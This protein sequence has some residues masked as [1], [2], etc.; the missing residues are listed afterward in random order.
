ME[1][2]GEQKKDKITFF[3][4]FQPDYFWITRLN[5]FVMHIYCECLSELYFLDRDF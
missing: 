5:K 2:N 1:N 4:I 3:S